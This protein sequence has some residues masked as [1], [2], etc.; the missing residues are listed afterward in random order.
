[1][2]VQSPVDGVMGKE[3]ECRVTPVLARPPGVKG[4]HAWAPWTPLSPKC[5]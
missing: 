2:G 4:A 3:D 5:K 1:M